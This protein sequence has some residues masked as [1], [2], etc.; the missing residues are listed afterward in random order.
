[1]R[2]LYAVCETASFHLKCDGK[3]LMRRKRKESKTKFKTFIGHS[4]LR[5]FD[6]GIS[7]LRPFLSLHFSPLSITFAPMCLKGARTTPPVAMQGTHRCAAFARILIEQYAIAL[8][9]FY[10]RSQFLL[11]SSNL[12]SDWQVCDSMCFECTRL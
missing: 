3:Y 1:M 11:F 6:D 4:A 9:D 12:E 8:F 7:Y 10:E 5:L 2:I